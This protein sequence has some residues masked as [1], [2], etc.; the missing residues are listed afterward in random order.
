[1]TPTPGVTRYE[2]SNAAVTFT[3]SWFTNTYAGH[4]GG[5]AR[6]SVDAGDRATLTFNGG[7]ISV[8]AYQ[9]EWSGI[10]RVF[11]D[12]TLRATVDFYRTPARAQSVVF[13]AS[14]LGAGLHT[15]AVEVTG[16]RS[17][18]SGNNTI[19][20]DAFESAP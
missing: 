20:V 16:T 15:I 18:A 5:T 14:G 10:G 4:S 6:L 12:G 19:W 17:A 3:G 1:M 9:D 7:T 11:I 13:T 2:D 8:I